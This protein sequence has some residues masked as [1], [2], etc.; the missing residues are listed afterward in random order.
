MTLRP[1][2]PLYQ[3]GKVMAQRLPSPLKFKLKV[4]ALAATPSNNEFVGRR[5][6]NIQDPH[7]FAAG[8]IVI[9]LLLLDTLASF[10]Y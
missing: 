9:R 2:T 1:A 5:D 4:C 3:E 8:S 6:P 7:P 10:H